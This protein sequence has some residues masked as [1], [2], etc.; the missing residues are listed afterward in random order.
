MPP[1][2]ADRPLLPP[3]D[4]PVA[5]VTDIAA[6]LSSPWGLTD[7]TDGT[8][9]ISLRGD[10]QLVTVNADGVQT[11]VTGPG[12][13]QLAAQTVPGGE[14]GLLG[15]AFALADYPDG[16]R[17]PTLF[18]YRTGSADNAVVRGQ[19]MR[20]GDGWSLGE[21]TTVIDGIP[22]ANFHNGGRLALGPDGFL[23]VTTGDAGERDLAQDLGYLGGKILRI[24]LDGDHAPGNPFPGSPVWSY[25]HRNVQGLDWDADGRMFAS[26]FGQDTWDELNLI[27]PGGN[28]GWPITEGAGDEYASG[29]PVGGPS[30]TDGFRRPLVVWHTDDA[31]PSGLDVAGGAIYLAGL[32]GQTL[33]RVPYQAQADGAVAVGQA[34]PFLTGVGRVRAVVSDQTGRLFV[35]TNNTDGRGNPN[36]LDDRLLCIAQQASAP[37]PAATVPGR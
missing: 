3:S 9:V 18:I 16:A 22:K 11:P 25:G 28:Y 26:E 17:H 7:L 13:D 5:T 36:R 1:D 21:L 31:S 34:Q 37:C 24:T 10:A 32:R 19:W 15:T 33:W 2:T 14:G 29:Q 6:Q 8:F 30:V 27:V 35:L 12:A 4:A 23:Y 20:D